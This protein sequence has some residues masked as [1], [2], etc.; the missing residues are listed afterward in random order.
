MEETAREASLVAKKKKKEKK[1]VKAP[2]EAIPA[3]D[4]D[5]GNGDDEDDGD[6]WDDVDWD[7]DEWDE[8]NEWNQEKGRMRKPSMMK[9][10]ISMKITKNSDLCLMVNK[11]PRDSCVPK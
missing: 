4:P 3:G 10:Q 5:G 2:K 7:D 11:T 1:P 9:S 6:D 8:W